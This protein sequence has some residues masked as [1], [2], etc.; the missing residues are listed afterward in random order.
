MNIA[1]KNP[2]F[3]AVTGQR[4]YVEPMLKLAAC[5]RSTWVSAEIDFVILIF[6]RFSAFV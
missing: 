1:R 3:R 6:V 5:S 2:G 4:F